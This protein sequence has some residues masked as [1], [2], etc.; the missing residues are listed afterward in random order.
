MA[1][2]LRSFEVTHREWDNYREVVNART[3][4]QAKRE[5]MS[6]LRE[7]CPDGVAWTALRARVLGPP[8]TSEQFVRNAHYRGLP[9][10]RCGDRVAVGAG[11]GAIVGHNSSANFDVL[12]DDDSPEHAGQVLNVHPASCQFEEVRR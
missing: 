9:N 5:A 10:V 2:A 4:G 3:P 12:F 11:R 6:G 7:V 1:D 8:A